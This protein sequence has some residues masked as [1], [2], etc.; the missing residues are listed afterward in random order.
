M[1]SNTGI[2][3][4]QFRSEQVRP[5]G[6]VE[7][8]WSHY[9]LRAAVEAYYNLY[10]IPAHPPYNVTPLLANG[11]Q[12]LPTD[13]T[14]DGRFLLYTQLAS[15]IASEKGDLWLMRWGEAAIPRH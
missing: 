11:L 9:R 14:P 5:L 1:T 13:I 3:R 8:R 7:P 2:G 10:R 15:D 12:N 4:G 6:L